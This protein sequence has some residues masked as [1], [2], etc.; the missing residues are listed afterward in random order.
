M[1]LFAPD[2]PYFKE[3]PMWPFINP[4]F[5]RGPVARKMRLM[6][7]GAFL[8]LVLG[9][10]GCAKDEPMPGEM[11][12]IR[13]ENHDIYNPSKDMA[14]ATG[15]GCGENYQQAMVN[16]KRIAEF[17]LRSLT[18]HRKYSIRYNTVELYPDINNY[19]IKMLATAYN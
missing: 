8:A 14:S 9:I 12:E 10:Q 16:A 2:D 7:L 19:C 17:N 1:F 13:D 11:R 3:L 4:L 15:Y 5:C 18:G 6:A